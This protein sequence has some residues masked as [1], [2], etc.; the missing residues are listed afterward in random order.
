MRRTYRRLLRWAAGL[1]LARRATSTPLEFSRELVAATPQV[2]DAVK[3]ITA[4][5][6]DVRYGEVDLTEQALAVAS[7]ALRRVDREGVMPR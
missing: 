7:E 6:E 5:Y 1:G 3:Q 4:L 2:A